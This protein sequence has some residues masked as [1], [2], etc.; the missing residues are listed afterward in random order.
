MAIGMNVMVTYNI[1]TDL[2]LTNGV[3]GEIVNIVLDENK[4]PLPQTPVVFLKYPPAYILKLSRTHLT[5]LSSLNEGVIPVQPMAS[6]F[7]IEVIESGKPLKR[8]VQ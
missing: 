7:Q 4:P 3:R 8:T 2:D 1:E 6:K 5:K